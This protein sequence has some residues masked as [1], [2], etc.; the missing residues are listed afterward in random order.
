MRMQL[1]SR[2]IRFSTRRA[3]VSD[4]VRLR[5]LIYCQL[6]YHEPL[7]SFVPIYGNVVYDNIARE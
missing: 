3:S 5:D 1:L 6:P 7:P 4:V 2:R